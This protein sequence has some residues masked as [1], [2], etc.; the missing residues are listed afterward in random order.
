VIVVG[1]MHRHRSSRSLVDYFNRRI[2][3]VCTYLFML[4]SDMVVCVGAG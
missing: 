2:T 1:A 4:N 3:G